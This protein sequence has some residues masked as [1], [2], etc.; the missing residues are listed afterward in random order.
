MITLQFLNVDRNG[1]LVREIVWLN[2]EWLDLNLTAQVQYDQ[3]LEKYLFFFI[4][5]SWRWLHI[6]DI[7]LCLIL[8]LKDWRCAR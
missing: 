3:Q 5:L 6:C 1:H 4:Y 7:D 8:C 2:T